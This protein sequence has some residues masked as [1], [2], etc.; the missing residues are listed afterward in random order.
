MWHAS[1]SVWTKYGSRKVDRPELAERE[2]IRLLAGVGGEREWWAWGVGP[3]GGLVG[4]LRV[5]L[6]AAEFAMMPAGIAV[7]DA[8][9]AG[10]ERP[11]TRR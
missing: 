1:V 3:A 5:A 11:R 10:P 6:T 9:D 4:Y 2:G 8:G 7:S